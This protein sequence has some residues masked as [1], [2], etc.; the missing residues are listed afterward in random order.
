[1]LRDLHELGISVWWPRVFEK[2]VLLGASPG[3]SLTQHRSGVIIPYN[4]IR[5]SIFLSLWLR[6]HSC[7]LPFRNVSQDFALVLQTERA[8]ISR[9]QKKKKKSYDSWILWNT[10]QRMHG[11]YFSG[12][13]NRRAMISTILINL[14]EIHQ[15]RCFPFFPDSEKH[16]KKQSY[17]SPRLIWRVSVRATKCTPDTRM[18]SS[19]QTS[20]RANT[21]RAYPV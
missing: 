1:M 16:A 9:Q 17:A 8:P 18:P 7:F 14:D 4:E 19:L 3:R 12:E 11:K 5:R 10:K 21:L 20:I 15:L 13:S 2:R 6:Q